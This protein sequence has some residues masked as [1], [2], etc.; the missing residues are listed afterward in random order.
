MKKVYLLAAAACT[1]G[2]VFTSC[3]EVDNP[4]PQH[5][6]IISFEKQALNADGFWIG[7]PNANGFSYDDGYG[8]TTTAYDCTYTE[9]VLTLNT[10]YSLSSWGYDF[11]SGYAVSNRTETD[12][13]S[14][15][16]DQYNNVTGKAHSGQN[17]CVVQQYYGGTISINGTTGAVVDYLY[18][19][20]SAYTAASIVK[21]DDYAG[22]AFDKTDFLTCTIT[23]THPDGTTASI[24]IDLASNGDYVKT[25]KRADL[26]ELGIV[27]DLSFSFTGSRTGEWGLNTPAYICIDDVTLTVY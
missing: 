27:T 19:T 5:N 13:A 11:W 25:W 16:P 6:V 10:T 1:C 18:Y 8:G 7:E 17:F 14:L 23:G 3:S 2:M 12:Y 9:G 26:S 24:D 20:N 22:P 15:T 4:I 21:G